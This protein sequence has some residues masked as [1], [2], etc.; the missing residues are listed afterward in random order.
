MKRKNILILLGSILV[1]IFITWYFTKPSAQQGQSIKTEV[2]F[3]TFVIDVTTTGE[4]EARSSEKIQGP[5]PMKLRNARIWQYRI[6]DMVPDGTVVDSGQWVATLDRS[7]LE[8]KIKDQELE[9]EKLQTQYLQKQLDT[10]MTL[11]NARDELINLKF[12]LE[13]K[14]IVVEQSIYEPPATQRQVQIDY[15]K[16]LRTYNQSTENYQLKLQ[17]ADADM[18]EVQANLS[19]AQNRLDEFKDLLGDFVILAPKP[20]MV[21]YKKGWDG[22]K[23]G[24]GAQVSAWDNVVA[25]LP[26]LSAMN[27]QTFVNE[28]DISKVSEGQAAEIEIDAFPG[29]TFDGS[30]FEVANMGEQMRNSNAKVFEVIIHI[31]GFDS[32]LRPSMTTKNRIIT[33]I[34]DSVLY[35]PIE[36]VSSNDSIS[37]VYFHGRKHQVIPGLSNESSI[38]IREGLERG[39]DVYLVPPSDSKDW[40]ID[41]LDKDIVEKYKKE[42]EDKNQPDTVKV[43]KDQIP[44]GKFD[45]K[46]KGDYKMGKGKRK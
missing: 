30:V 10:T 38:I 28:I 9:V 8:N 43:E 22:Q 34:I 2:K 33:N 14:K 4:L 36:C 11:R 29:K 21:T 27:S 17:K 42:E 12:T 25:T 31:D 19:K 23:Q 6:E 3:G 26:D 37:Y 18:R 20:G 5:N 1:L 16:T 46:R 39:D 40:D 7:D 24:I 35:V 41:F 44:K 13:E 45:G 32:I 15:D